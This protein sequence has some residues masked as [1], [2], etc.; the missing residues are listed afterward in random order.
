MVLS[1]ETTEMLLDVL[2]REAG[3]SR[4]EVVRSLIKKEFRKGN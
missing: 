4:S 1:V 3:V 2:A